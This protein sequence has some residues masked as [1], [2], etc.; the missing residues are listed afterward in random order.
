M[1]TRALVLFDVDGTL[2]I[3]QG[4]TSRCILRACRQLFGDE[5]A[6]GDITVGMLDQQIFADLCVANGI[7]DAFSHLDAYKRIY[8][9]LLEEEL[10]QKRDDIIVLPGVRELLARLHGTVEIATGIVSGNFR[11]AVEFKIEYASLDA[12]HFPIMACAEDGMSRNDLPRA[13]M[14]A[15]EAS[16]GRAIASDRVVIV[17]DTP[18][19][20]ECAR[21]CGASVISVA[22]GRY[23]QSA[24]DGADLLLANLGD[25]NQVYDFLAAL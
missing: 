11:R 6:W 18:R 14:N 13:A 7:Q 24:L 19:D 1:A 2:L 21:A 15:Y 12:S 22:T 20:I 25:V 9:A 23:D 16:C 17:G 5:F 10:R 4:A 3:T 8:L